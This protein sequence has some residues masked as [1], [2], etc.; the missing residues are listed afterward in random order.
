MMETSQ[1]RNSNK[2]ALTRTGFTLVEVLVVIAIM[3]V[4]ATLMVSMVSK[5][6]LGARR[7]ECANNMRQLGV[8]LSSYATDHGGA[9]PLT[10]HSTGIRV[11][12][13]WVYQLREYIGPGF[14]QL[15]VSPADPKG[16][17]RL[18]SAGTSYILNSFLF[19]PEYDPFG[20]PVG[21]P[22]NRP[23]AIPDHAGTLM[24]F[25]I[26][27]SAAPGMQNDHTHSRR[28]TDWNSVL[29]DISPD[30]HRTGSANADHTEGSSNY[31]FVDGHVETWK[32]NELKE[33]IEKSVN[34]AQPP[35]TS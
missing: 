1:I 23:S 18:E 20:N 19:V 6:R 24:A 9:Y 5:M 35:V 13:A 12:Q 16:E 29:Q 17:E 27:E 25:T 2:F 4:L 28:W 14:D 11:D 7:A 15:R 10:S 32:A 8:A 26:S 34:P 22:L 21:T 30:L 33:K 3:A 31:L